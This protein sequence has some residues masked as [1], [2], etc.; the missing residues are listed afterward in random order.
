LNLPERGI[1]LEDIKKVEALTVFKGKMLEN[2]Y[3]TLI[4]HTRLGTVRQRY[5]N[6]LV[7]ATYTVRD[8]VKAITGNDIDM[9]VR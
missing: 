6:D 1:P 9:R 8:H 5:V 2:T 4:V 3:G 7:K